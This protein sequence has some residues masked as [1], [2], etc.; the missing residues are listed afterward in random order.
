MWN[1]KTNQKFQFQL[2]W[3]ILWWLWSLD[4]FPLRFAE[5]TSKLLELRVRKQSRSIQWEFAS[6]NTTH[7]I[8]HIVPQILTIPLSPYCGM[9]FVLCKIIIGPTQ[10]LFSPN[11]NEA[12]IPFEDSPWIL[13]FHLGKPS[14]NDRIC[15]M[16]AD[17]AWYAS[18]WFLISHDFW[19]STMHR[20]MFRVDK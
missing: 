16:N 20:E 15:Q 2:M 8:Q 1:W 6:S 12:I 10:Y 11:R 18:K 3:M 9:K 5:F 13:V 7:I 17:Y 4:T 14:E 19:S